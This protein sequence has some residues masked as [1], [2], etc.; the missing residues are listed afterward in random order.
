MLTLMGCHLPQLVETGSQ[1]VKVLS[2]YLNF[3]IVRLV[4]DM[5]QPVEMYHVLHLFLVQPVK[6][7]FQLVENG[8][9]KFLFALN[10]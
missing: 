2:L 10:W 9:L 6:D 1:S 5:V 3:F 8:D 7:P 4:E